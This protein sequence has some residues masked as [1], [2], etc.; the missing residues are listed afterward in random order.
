M[1][2]PIEKIVFVSNYVNFQSVYEVNVEKAEA[3]VSIYSNIQWV[4]ER[5]NYAHMDPCKTLL[6]WSA[7]ILY[8]QIC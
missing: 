1:K 5:L 6:E 2:I 4:D 8:C 3:D 7:F